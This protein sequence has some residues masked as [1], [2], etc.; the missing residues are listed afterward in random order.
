[1]FT[2]LYYHSNNSLDDSLKIFEDDIKFSKELSIKVTLPILN[3]PDLVKWAFIGK[4]QEIQCWVWKHTGGHEYL[5]LSLTHGPQGKRDFNTWF[6]M[7]EFLSKPEFK[8]I[9]P[10]WVIYIEYKII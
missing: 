5:S 6:K 10:C 2:Y 1:M 7:I 9:L 3:N 8:N 4:C